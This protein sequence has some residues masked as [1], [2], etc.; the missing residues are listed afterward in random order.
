MADLKN[1]ICINNKQRR[2]LY[3]FYTFTNQWKTTEADLP[4]DLE[5]LY[6]WTDG[7]NTT[8]LIAL[9]LFRTGVAA[10]SEA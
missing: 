6:I 9:M 3:I 1:N 7:T 2:H 10:L 5:K 8:P 4:D